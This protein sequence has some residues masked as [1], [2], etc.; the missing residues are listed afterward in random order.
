[1]NVMWQMSESQVG[2]GLVTLIQPVGQQVMEHIANS[3]CNLVLV[4]Q[5]M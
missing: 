3:L 2:L 1:M 5:I 4:E